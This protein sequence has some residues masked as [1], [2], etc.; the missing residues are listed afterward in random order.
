MRN[1]IKTK[2]KTIMIAV[3]LCM[4]LVSG[5]VLSKLLGVSF[6]GSNVGQG[7]T[8]KVGNGK[9]KIISEYDSFAQYIA[10]T[11]NSVKTVTIPDTINAGGKTYKVV[12]IG[13]YALNDS[14][15][16]LKKVTIGR[17]V[18]CIG[19]MAFR[20]AGKLK[21][22]TIKTTHLTKEN[23]KLAS[24]HALNKKVTIIVPEQ[25]LEDYTKILKSK[26]VGL[27]GKN[28]KIKGKKM[29]ELYD[30]VFDLNSAVPDPEVKMG[31][32][33]AYELRLKQTKET[34]EYSVGDTI[35]V[36]MK[37]RMDQRIYY[38][39]QPYMA[40]NGTYM[41]CGKCGRMFKPDKGLSNANTTL[42][43]HTYLPMNDNIN[44][45]LSNWVFGY[46]Y[47]E[48]FV[49]WR[50]IYDQNPC[51][52]VIKI[53]LPDGLDYKEGSEGVFVSFILPIEDFYGD[54]PLRV[55][56]KLYHTEVNGREMIITINDLKVFTLAYDNI[57]IEFETKMN[58]NASDSNTIEASL[59]YNHTDGDKSVDFNEVTV[60][61]PSLR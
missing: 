9:Y 57:Y 25:K 22:M 19:K 34:N 50:Q 60:L 14:G 4:L 24:F 51:S 18:I 54:P 49:A 52:A 32:N 5:L 31:I 44:C 36:A 38:R 59:V 28:Q 2:K 3:A 27:T 17:N 48:S 13:D 58:E 7:D 10:P 30:A 12:S 61:K 26:D 42:E 29:E 35:P 8:V 16:T 46:K 39:W 47:P 53:T 1:M 40:D 23:V 33:T 6:A 15:R 20:Y 41:I 21:T 37:I 43:N 45:V 55:K 11:K 56:E